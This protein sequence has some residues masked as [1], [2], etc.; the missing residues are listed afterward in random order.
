MSIAAGQGKLTRA[1][2]NL[3]LNWRETQA[4]WNDDVS[5]RVEADHIQPLAADTRAS[6]EAIGQMGQS[7]LTMKKDCE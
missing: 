4:H 6:I 7:L 3:E 2:K 1:L 5:R